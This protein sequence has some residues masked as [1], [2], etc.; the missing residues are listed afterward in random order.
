[1][2]VWAGFGLAHAWLIV[3]GV[4]VAPAGVFNDLDLYRWWMAVG[5]AEGTWP[6]LDGPWVYPA[7]ALVPMA[8]PAAVTTTSATGYALAWCAL[9]TVLD[10]V[11]VRALLRSGGRG[12][13]GTWWWLAFLVL[14][15]PVAI[16]RLDGVVAPVLVLALL[17]GLRRPRLA[18]ALMTAGAWIKVAPGALLLPL[19]AVARRGVRDVVVPAAVV[20]AVV[21]GAV[22]AGGGIANIAS[23]LSTQGGRGL[24]V[25]S[26][27]ATPWVLAS[28]VRDDIRIGRNDAL[29]TWEITGPGTTTAADAIDVL[30]VLAVGLVAVLVWSSWR[31]GRAVAA[32]LPG[33]LLML[34]VLV[35]TNKVG[36]PQ[37]LTWLAAPLVVL[38]TGRPDGVG[39]G[40][41]R[42]VGGLLLLAAGLTQ[43]V[44]PWAY[45]HLLE[46]SAP[47]A[48]ML[49]AR[50]LLLLA[51]LVLA[52][53]AVRGG[54]DV[55]VPLDR[56]CR[57][58]PPTV[59]DPTPRPGGSPL[60]GRRGRSDLEPA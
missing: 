51:V 15:G 20:C 49:A 8:L 6:V 26:V 55:P 54:W 23:F 37:F 46:A 31:S 17:A 33:A 14:L 9:V 60:G 19:V 58:I 24:Q 44:Y 30:L 47:V 34:T 45:Q 50:N 53:L 39:R 28:L 10:A 13:V 36:S 25:E 21:V 40:V 57:L 11:A 27:A 18:A 41:L 29:A 52:V 1:M 42:A 43:V 12:V 59:D 38:L 22:A 35:V 5:L 2:A 7:G 3:L 16:G 48:V 56:V 4:V 32:F